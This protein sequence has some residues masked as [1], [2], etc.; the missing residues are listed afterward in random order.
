MSISP[1]RAL[2]WGTLL[3]AVFSAAVLACDGRAWPEFSERA[4][5]A[6]HSGR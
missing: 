6:K 2:T 5:M 4:S 3:A 1:I